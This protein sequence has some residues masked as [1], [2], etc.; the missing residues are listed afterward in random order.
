M[1][2][3]NIAFLN[4]LE[5]FLFCAKQITLPG[6]LAKVHPKFLLDMFNFSQ[7]LLIPL[8]FPLS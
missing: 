4:V 5:A 7:T 2:E 8:S 3:I 6:L 1:R